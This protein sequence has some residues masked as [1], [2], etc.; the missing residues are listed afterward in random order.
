MEEELRCAVC[1]GVFSEPVLLPCS[2]AMCLKCACSTQR[3]LQ[4]LLQ[5]PL[6]GIPSSGHDP[7]PPDGGDSDK[8]SVYSETDSG[9]VLAASRPTS[10]VSSPENL[11]APDAEQQQQQQQGVRC[12]VCHKICALGPGQ[13]PQDLPRFTAMARIIARTRGGED[14]PASAPSAG[15]TLPPCQLCEG[16]PRPATT[17][18]QQCQVIYCGPC[19]KSCHP[20]RGP[21]ATHTLG[22]VTPLGEPGAPSGGGL[23]WGEVCL[24]HGERPTVYCLVCR[25][26]GCAECAPMHSMHDLQPLDHLAKTHKVRGRGLGGV[27]G[28]ERCVPYP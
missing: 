24:A 28:N 16:P 1:G 21:L 13:A 7:D 26:A 25:W 14:G 23:V 6:G 19:L 20:P 18:C 12:H 9:V 4:A 17:E 8:A 5:E 27:G 3:P 10:Y 22:S 2:H 11:G 15:A